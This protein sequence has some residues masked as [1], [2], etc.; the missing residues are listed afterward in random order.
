M[1]HNFAQS[2]NP[3]NRLSQI[4][5]DQMSIEVVETHT[6]LPDIVLPGSIVVDCGGLKIGLA[7]CSAT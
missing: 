4:L 5:R 6:I 7:R 2:W 1:T 3:S